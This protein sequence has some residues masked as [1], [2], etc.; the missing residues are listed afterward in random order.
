MCQCNCVEEWSRIKKFR[1]KNKTQA[2]LFCPIEI[3][4]Y[5]LAKDRFEGK[6]QKNIPKMKIEHV[7]QKKSNLKTKHGRGWCLKM[8]LEHVHEKELNLNQM[9]T[10]KNQMAWLK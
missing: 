8:E 3:I 6:A 2:R 7:E 1:Y 4:T 5:K 10:Y 9:Y